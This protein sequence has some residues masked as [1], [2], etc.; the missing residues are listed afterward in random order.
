MSIQRAKISRTWSDLRA[1]AT[2]L[3]TYMIDNSYYPILTT[4]GNLSNVLPVK[5]YSG[6][7]TDAWGQQFQYLSSPTGQEYAL[8]S[9]GADSILDTAWWWNFPVILDHLDIINPVGFR[10]ILCRPISYE[11]QKKIIQEGCDLIYVGGQRIG[12]L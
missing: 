4:T 10:S 6:T 5:Y 12:S 9:A 7:S 2:A 8:K 11:D 3:G 1:I